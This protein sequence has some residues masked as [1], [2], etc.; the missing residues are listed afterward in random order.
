MKEGGII[1]LGIERL[2]AADS[3]SDPYFIEFILT[4][5]PNHGKLVKRVGVGVGDG[6][7]PG[8]GAGPGDEEQ[9]EVT[10]FSLNE[11]SGQ[12]HGFKLLAIVLL[13]RYGNQTVGRID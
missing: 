11:V 8:V 5:K 1:C 13:D 4:K 12:P 6:D 9:V 3:D 10:R 7:G 2:N